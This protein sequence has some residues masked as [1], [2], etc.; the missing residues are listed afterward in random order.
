MIQNHVVTIG[1][2]FTIL[3]QRC[4]KPMGYLKNYMMPVF[5]GG[6]SMKEAL[7]PVLKVK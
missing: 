6:L 1:V 2:S 7:V 4:V 3:R 5:Q